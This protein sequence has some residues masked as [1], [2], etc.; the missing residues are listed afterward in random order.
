MKFRSGGESTSAGLSGQ[1][2]GS[3]SLV[4]LPSR[5]IVLMQL[6]WNDLQPAYEKA[7]AGKYEE[8]QLVI[9]ADDRPRGD[10]A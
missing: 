6:I 7:K 1:E 2:T 8:N 10:G 4:A 9:T 3:A 5:P